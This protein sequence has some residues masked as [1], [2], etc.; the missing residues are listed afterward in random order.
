MMNSEDALRANALLDAII[1]AL[2]EMR[3]CT[4]IEDRIDEATASFEMAEKDFWS[5][6]EFLQRAGAFIAHEY[7]H[8]LAFVQELTSEQANAEALHL[9]DQHYLGK[10]HHGYDAALRDARNPAWGIQH[11]LAAMAETIR[12]IEQKKNKIRAYTALV[13]P[14][15]WK[16]KHDLVRVTLVRLKQYMPP[17]ILGCDPEQLAEQCFELIEAHYDSNDEIRR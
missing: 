15:D 16:T 8:G 12:G 9:L 4:D 10:H 17:D 3:S 14:T 5:S 7:R 1:C 13:D 6:K 2:H 11:V